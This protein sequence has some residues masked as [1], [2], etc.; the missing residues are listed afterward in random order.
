MSPT[1]TDIDQ[2]PDG[3]ATA[4]RDCTHLMLIIASSATKAT[5]EAKNSPT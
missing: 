3:E 1:F 4:W 2:L 5:N